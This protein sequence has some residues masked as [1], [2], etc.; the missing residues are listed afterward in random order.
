LMVK[1]FFD[2]FFGPAW[3]DLGYLGVFGRW[4]GVNW[5]WAEMLVI[6]HASFNIAIPILIV[7]T[8]YLQR[9]DDRWISDRELYG[10]SFLLMMLTI[11]GY[12]M[13]TPYRSPLFQYGLAALLVV[14]LCFEAWNFTA[15]YG[16]CGTKPLR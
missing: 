11:L 6:Y 4:A 14:L 2:P 3:L 16:T 10:F 15:S 12:F 9:R 13:L 8:A 7:E 1:N 5:V